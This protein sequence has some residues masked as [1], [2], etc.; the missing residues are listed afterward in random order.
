MKTKPIFVLLDSSSEP[1]GV[2]PSLGSVCDWIR[3]QTGMHATLTMTRMNGPDHLYMEL[4]SKGTEWVLWKTRMIDVD[5]DGGSLPAGSDGDS[6]AGV[7][8]DGGMRTAWIDEETCGTTRA[9]KITCCCD[10][11]EMRRQ[12]T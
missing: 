2:F 8:A 9:P 10:M 7:K 12:D 1:E 5:V 3:E 4:E 11:C 6:S